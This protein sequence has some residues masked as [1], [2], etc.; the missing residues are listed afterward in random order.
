MSISKSIISVFSLLLICLHSFAAN[1]EIEQKIITD[2]L[3]A[4][5]FENIRVAYTDENHISV[6]IED[7][8]Y[9]S[10]YYGISKALQI[11]NEDKKDKNI[12]LIVLEDHM[13]RITI[14]ASYFNNAWDIFDIRYGGELSNELRKV[15][16]TESSSYKADFVLYPGYSINNNL[17]DRLWSGHIAINP[18]LEMHLWKGS[19]IILQGHIPVWDNYDYAGHYNYSDKLNITRA[20]INQQLIST[21]N[22]NIRLSAGLFNNKRNGF[23]ARI[24][25]HLSN[26]L[27]LGVKAGYTGAY[28]VEHQKLRIGQLNRINALGYINYYEPRTNLQA[29]LEFGQFLYEDRGA[30][31][32][33]NRH[34]ADYAAGIFGFITDAGS[35]LGF[36]FSAPVGPRKMG[37]HRK[38]RLRAPEALSFDLEEY[39]DNN[40]SN[41][42]VLMGYQYTT[43]PND[44]DH[45]SRYWQPEFLKKYIIK[46][47]NE[48]IK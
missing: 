22:W 19:Q 39:I 21:N 31:L 7:N 37:R 4:D 15:K 34:Y 35:S 33:I 28:N 40:T 10:K 42:T 3:V 17:Y 44:N 16:E 8:H 6:V 46:T 41:S 5:G 12:K 30:S 43:H 47:L 26:T 20:C 23:D 14:Q 2:N 24:I 45:S 32:K 18:A 9:H 11:I 38:A 29:E 48:E 1:F 27:D 36:S 13:P 25:Y